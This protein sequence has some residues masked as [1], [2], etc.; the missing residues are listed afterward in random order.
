MG[1]SKDGAYFILGNKKNT[2]NIK[3]VWPGYEETVYK[4]GAVLSEFKVD[5]AGCKYVGKDNIGKEDE[6]LYFFTGASYDK[7]NNTYTGGDTYA[8]YSVTKYSGDKLQKMRSVED[9]ILNDPVFGLNRFRTPKD[10]GSFTSALTLEKEMFYK[11]A[12]QRTGPQSEIEIEIDVQKKYE[13]QGYGFWEVE[14]KET[15][16]WSFD[17][18]YRISGM[19]HISDVKLNKKGAEAVVNE[20]RII[21]VF[22]G[23]AEIPDG[24]PDLNTEEWV[25]MNTETSS[26]LQDEFA[27]S[28]PQ[29]AASPEPE[30]EPPRAVTPTWTAEQRQEYE[31]VKALAETGDGPAINELARLHWDGIG[32][33]INQR[34]SL[35]LLEHMRKNNL[36]VNGFKR[37][38]LGIWSKK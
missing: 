20:Q 8:A 9:I 3:Q 28:A 27:F 33:E 17:Q 31:R 23:S 30:P 16:V 12:N 32:C 22:A 10:G 2:D 18:M 35:Q 24:F 11:S 14:G 4:D 36:P 34:Y 6:D 1:I 29:T 15:I 5:L 13:K 26:V 25:Q 19:R 37:N 38:F 7:S 21:K